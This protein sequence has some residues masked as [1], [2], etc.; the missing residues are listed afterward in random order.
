MICL[1]PAGCLIS[2]EI[3][4]DILY[5]IDRIIFHIEKIHNFMIYKYQVDK[6]TPNICIRNYIVFTFQRKGKTKVSPTGFN[7]I[8]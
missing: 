8:I 5:L 1:S 7:H 2:F 4:I 3:I 6:S